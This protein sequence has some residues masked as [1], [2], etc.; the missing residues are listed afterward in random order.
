MNQRAFLSTADNYILRIARRYPDDAS[1]LEGVV[2]FVAN[3]DKVAFHD[4]QTLWKILSSVRS[5][6]FD[7]GSRR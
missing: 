3:G 4:A 1:R 5:P 6:D 2:E 7:S